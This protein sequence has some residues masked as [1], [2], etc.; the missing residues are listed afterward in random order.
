MLFSG[1]CAA[2]R[3]GGVKA[4]EKRASKFTIATT[5]ASFPRPPHVDVG[6]AFLLSEDCLKD[7]HNLAERADRNPPPDPEAKP[8]HRD[9][10]RRG[11]WGPRRQTARNKTNNFNEIE[12]C[13][14]GGQSSLDAGPW[15]VGANSQWHHLTDGSEHSWPQP[16][17]ELRVTWPLD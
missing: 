16:S 2:G 17:S 14:R 1:I 5:C 4:G 10:T 13:E 6:K 9:K 12:R 8:R 15:A 3:G 11:G 7:W